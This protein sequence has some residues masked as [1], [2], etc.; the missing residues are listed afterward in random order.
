VIAMFYYLSIARTMW[1]DAPAVPDPIRPGLALNFTIA[2]LAVVALAVGIYP[3]AFA[4]FA[5]A[6]T[7]IAAGP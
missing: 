2:A 4:G 5:D 7:L 3:E 6:S 1:M